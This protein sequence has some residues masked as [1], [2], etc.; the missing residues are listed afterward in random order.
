M[1]PPVDE[2]VL[3]NNPQFASL[4]HTLT[5]SIL[6]P[7]GST[8]NDALQKEREAVR[9]EL[10]TH[11]LNHAK[12]HLLAHAIA[13][14]TPPEPQTTRGTIGQQRPK[15]R[16]QQADLPEPLLDL[17]LLLPPLLDPSSPPLS[18]EET[19]ALLST[20]PLSDLDTLLPQLAPIIASSLRD[21]AISLA[22]VAHP[23]TNPSFLHRTIPRLAQDVADRVKALETSREALVKERLALTRDVAA[24]L[25][26]YAEAMAL[27]IRSLEGKH[28]VMA[29]SVE[30]RAAEVAAEA[31]KA[32][33]EARM[34]ECDVHADVYPPEA[35]RALQ[36]YN[37]HLRD[38]TLRMEESIRGLERELERYGVGVDGA[39]GK[40]SRM[41]EMARAKREMEREIEEVRRDLERLERA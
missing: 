17:L 2:S 26:K 20:P 22:R 15:P 27:L 40:E 6:N 25:R 18:S 34:A 24:L 28:G 35:V 33:L 16:Q 7:D 1:L 32:E 4:Y 21:S 12:H 29:R 37:A 23:A 36:N 31:R 14:A 9:E 13:T 39:G 38:A 3:Q 11:R 10:R 41:R 8:K 30:L 19:A 5:T